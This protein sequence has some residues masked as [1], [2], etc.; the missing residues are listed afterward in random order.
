MARHDSVKARLASEWIRRREL[1]FH[2]AV[3][4]TATVSLEDAEALTVAL[5]GHVATGHGSL[6][7]HSSKCVSGCGCSMTWVPYIQTTRSESSIEPFQRRLEGMLYVGGMHGLA[8]IAIEWLL[9]KVQP[10]IG[11]SSLRGDSELLRGG[12]GHLHLAGPGWAQHAADSRVLNMSVAAGRATVLGTLSDLQLDQRLQDHKVFVAP[13]LNG[14]GIATKN[15]LAM[16]HGI[17]LVTTYVGLNGLGLPLEQR[18]ILVSDTPD[19]FASHVLNVQSSEQVFNTTWRAALEHTRTYLSAHRQQAQL[20]RALGCTAQQP[21]AT[22][23][24]PDGSNSGLCESPRKALHRASQYS[25]SAPD[26]AITAIVLLGLGGT[27]VSALAASLRSPRACLVA[28]P[29]VGLWRAPLSAQIDHLRSILTEPAYCRAVE[30]EAGRSGSSHLLLQG[31]AME[32]AAVEQVPTSILAT[33]SGL[34]QLAQLLT[35][36]KVVVVRRCYIL[37]WAVQRLLPVASICSSAGTCAMMERQNLEPGQVVQELASLGAQEEALGVLLNSASVVWTSVHEDLWFQDDRGSLA[38]VTDQHAQLKAFLGLARTHPFAAVGRGAS[39][40]TADWSS[41]V[42]NAQAIKAQLVA[43]AEYSSLAS[44]CTGTGSAG[45]AVTTQNRT[46]ALATLLARVH[47]RPPL[48]VVG[49]HDISGG[50][51]LFGKVV[52]EACRAYLTPQLG[53]RCVTRDSEEHCDSSSA[54]VCF[55]R[56]ARFSAGRHVDRGYR[57]VHVIRSPLDM[58]TRSFQLQDPNATH[59]MNSSGLVA[60]LEAHWKVLSNGVLHTMQDMVESH[61]SDPHSLGVRIE[62]LLPD[63]RPNATMAQL[64]AFLINGDVVDARVHALVAAVSKAL[65]AAGR[66]EMQGETQRKHMARLLLRKPAKCQ[67]ITRLQQALG[68]PALTC[69][70]G[71]PKAT[72]TAGGGRSSGT[73]DEER[74][75]RRKLRTLR[76]Q[77]RLAEV[78]GP[79]MRDR[80]LASAWI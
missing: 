71:S 72:T 53:W 67:H 57:F 17:P 21:V 26:R 45:V 33:A 35:T 12:K 58:L 32:V 54:D 59:A 55:H 49:A 13:V 30:Q 34:H 25:P 5:A 47:V 74:G 23:T 76:R 80:R 38:T 31:F 62:D 41:M 37:S 4:G 61:A 8:V 46:S 42:G 66:A 19:G 48:L 27:N 24:Q 52:A 1:G 20:C 63:G 68:Y 16:A 77:R 3:D 56:Q 7:R 28:E 2:S 64:F 65:L 29:L 50:A 70:E 60:A 40:W 6:S 39:R 15:V 44:N 11:S 10:A 73:T 79:R 69:P 36:A 22:K 14:T 78:N 43:S 18:A 75:E 9:E 51:S